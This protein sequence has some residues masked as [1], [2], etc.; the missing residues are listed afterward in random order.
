M[1]FV[2]PAC[3]LLL[4][5]ASLLGQ[6]IL[7][8][9]FTAATE[10]VVEARNVVFGGERRGVPIG[11]DL[12]T[13]LELGARAGIGGGTAS[14]SI[15]YRRDVD[16]V[17]AEV[18]DH[19][20]CS[21]VTWTKSGEHATRL[22]VRARQPSLVRLVVSFS[23]ST[24]PRDFPTAWTARVDVGD[25]GSYEYDSSMGRAVFERLVQLDAAG[26]AIRTLTTGWA[27]VG[28]SGTLAGYDGT[29]TLEVMPVEVPFVEVFAAT[30]IQTNGIYGG[31]TIP[32][33]TG[34][35]PSANLPGSNAS[36]QATVDVADAGIEVALVENAAQWASTGPHDVV[37]VLRSPIA[38]LVRVNLGA[39]VQ[40]SAIALYSD[41]S[42]QVDIG[43]D[44]SFELRSVRNQSVGYEALLSVDA[45]GLR[46]RAR[47]GG[48]VTSGAT[49]SG[50]L[51]ISITPAL[52]CRFEAY[53]S[54]C[55]PALTG[56]VGLQDVVDLRLAGGQPDSLGKLLLGVN[57]TDLPLPF[58]SCRLLIEPLVG[59]AFPT[60]AVG[61][62][63]HRLRVPAGIVPTLVVQDIVL[64]GYAP[65]GLTAT[66]GLAIIGQ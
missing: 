15:R 32:T 52:R 25:D 28:D 18:R 13:G 14:T 53:G 42:G 41:W 54:S 47:A 11:T 39:T 51:T 35:R 48:F 20:A 23:R 30:P 7:D 2:H 24:Y 29:V 60:D 38:T 46:I 16:A 64:L 49:F 34:L 59:I 66:T 55:G 56:V 17:R 37:V 10:L 19:G 63:R 6:P 27:S 5:T 57:R 61:A 65:P 50:R 9:T 21:W 44:G 22:H 58:S 3:A 36:W 62:G 12:T 1:S 4:G 40:C 8:A 33:G 31:A 26:L 45:S 43:D